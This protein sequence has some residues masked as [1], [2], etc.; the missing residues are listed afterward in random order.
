MERR[1]ARLRAEGVDDARMIL[2][3]SI[4][5]RNYGQISGGVVLPVPPGM[6]DDAAVESL[7][8]GFWR[9]PEEGIRLRVPRVTLPIWRWSMPA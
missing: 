1:G 6:L 7:F 2:R 3:R 5:I 4:D 9:I 8:A